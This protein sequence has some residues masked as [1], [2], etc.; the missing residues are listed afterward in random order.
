MRDKSAENYN[1]LF[2]QVV[3]RM[4]KLCVVLDDRLCGNN[5][6]TEEVLNRSVQDMMSSVS[7]PQLGRRAMNYFTDFL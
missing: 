3:I 1:F 4:V 7:A 5:P 2:R 6:R